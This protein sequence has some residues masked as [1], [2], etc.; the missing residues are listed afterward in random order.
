MQ[1]IS[2]YRL[3]NKR[4]GRKEIA[5][6]KRLECYNSSNSRIVEEVVSHYHLEDI[7]RKCNKNNKNNNNK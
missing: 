7:N 3:R 5:R 4:L 6:L 1:G 2:R